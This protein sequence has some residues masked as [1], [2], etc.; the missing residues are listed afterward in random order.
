MKQ[1][2][3]APGWSRQMVEAI[4][5]IQSLI[6]DAYPG[7]SYDTSYQD[8]PAGMY[9]VATVDT[10]DLDAVVD[11]FIDRLLT[12]QVDEGIPLYVIPVHVSRRITAPPQPPDISPL[13]A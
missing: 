13:L 5:E 3:V 6:S 4:A 11:S 7:T 10:E 8:D 1:H 12:L 9:M 2:E